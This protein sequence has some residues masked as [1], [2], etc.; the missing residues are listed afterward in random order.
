M[1]L[2]IAARLGALFATGL[3]AERSA[4]RH[5]AASEERSEA[6]TG[7]VPESG[8]AGGHGPGQPET[9]RSGVRGLAGAPL[10]GEYGGWPPFLN[11]G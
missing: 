9:K 7:T 6:S 2:S 11:A 4:R 1:A 5:A 3:D 8:G 10:P